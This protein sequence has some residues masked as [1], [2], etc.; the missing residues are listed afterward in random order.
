MVLVTTAAAVATASLVAQAGPAAGARALAPA[1]AAS[2]IAWTAFWRPMVEVS[3]A[4]I[5]IRNILRSVFIPWP[6][7]DSVAVRWS[8]EVVAS[9]GTT[10][11]SW[12][13]ARSGAVDGWRA[14]S[15]AAPVASETTNEVV[16]HGTHS[17]PVSGT[18]SERRPANAHAVARAVEDR[19][20]ALVAAGHLGDPTLAG[21]A[22]RT[23]P[24]TVWHTRTSIAL[25]L[26]TAVSVVAL[27]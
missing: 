7:F 20:T 27:T 12:A 2:L 23:T 19:Y 10:T 14:R 25:A 21:L 3:D 18:V 8:L 11:T 1:A 16:D 22:A 26:L 15:A 17:D 5:T 24:R 4:G 9:D 13:A 6:A